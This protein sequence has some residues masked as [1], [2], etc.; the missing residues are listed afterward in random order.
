[1][2]IQ[3]ETRLRANL[4]VADVQTGL[5]RCNCYSDPGLCHYPDCDYSEKTESL[6]IA[7]TLAGSLGDAVAARVTYFSFVGFTYMYFKL[8]HTPGIPW[9]WLPF[10][11]NRTARFGVDDAVYYLDVIRARGMG[12]L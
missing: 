2:T 7:P 10:D 9:R 3:A 12:A 11:I 5:T 8:K 6:G 4:T 1:M